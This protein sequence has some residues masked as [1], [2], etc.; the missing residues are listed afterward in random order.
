MSTPFRNKK[1]ANS[2]IVVMQDWIRFHLEASPT[3][4]YYLRLCNKTLKII[5]QSELKAECGTTEKAIQLACV[6]TA[7]FED[8]ISETGIFRS[9]TEHHRE[10]YGRYL[11]FYDTTEAYY[12][13]ELNLCD[14]HLLTWHTLSLWEKEEE[15]YTVDPSLYESDNIVAA[16]DAI[17]HLFDEE[18]ESAPQ[19]EKMQEQLQLSPHAGMEEIRKLIVFFSQNSYLNK[20]EYDLFIAN[21]LEKTEDRMAEN[22]EEEDDIEDLDIGEMLESES[23]YFYDSS[24]NYNFNHYSA[25]SAQRANEQLSCLIGEKHPLYTLVKSISERKIGNF[26][27]QKEKT[28]ELIFEHISSGTPVNVSKEFH[29][30]SDKKLI[31]GRSCTVMGIVK[32]GDVWHQTGA[33][34]IL[35]YSEIRD[36]IRPGEFIFDDPEKKR[37]RLKKTETDFQQ[38]NHGKHI[39]FL[40]SPKEFL[41]FH[42][43][44]LDTLLRQESR[45]KAK[46]EKEKLLTQINLSL[47]KHVFPLTVFFNPVAGLEYYYDITKAIKD[48]ENLYFV[49]E[50]EYSLEELLIE[51]FYSKEFILYLIE[52]NLITFASE[53]GGIKT[54]VILN[55]TEFLLQYYKQD[56]C[57]T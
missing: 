14:I 20:I 50:K 4:S 35:D 30:F 43:C 22:I 19:N 26:L 21:E 3:D 23:M 2:N 32:W 6:L 15:N 34:V 7:Y 24:V 11:P 54:S 52:N 12:P 13:D 51:K 8:V 27:F 42:N 36:N 25:L 53:E 46:K 38:I 55:N 10:R 16:L 28:S 9:F 44:L 47:K 29:T 56:D 45:K 57:R 40:N 1:R 41:D 18:F 33:A 49:P 17:Y 5:L 39:A 48:P 37:N 31:P